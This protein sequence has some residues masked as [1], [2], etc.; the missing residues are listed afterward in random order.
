MTK[1]TIARHIKDNPH[2]AYLIEGR[3]AEIVPE[4]FASLEAEGFSPAGNP[5]LY[6]ITL[7]TMKVDDARE[8]RAQAVEKSF[9]PKGKA[10]IIAANAILGDAENTLL[11]MLEEPVPGTRFF[12]I[13]PDR[14][15]LLGTLLSRMHVIAGER[16]SEKKEAEAFV[17]M[18]PAARIEYLKNFMAEAKE[19]EEDRA[20][21][22]ARSRALRFLDSLESVLH[23]QFFGG[24]S[25]PAHEV[26]FFEQIFRV[27][28]YLRMPGSSVKNLME[29]VALAVPAAM[30]AR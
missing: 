8:L 14:H 29:S 25:A 12:L 2:H 27:R 20:A 6:Q 5:D 22:S 10:F 3:A 9:N 15:V 30:P 21:D 17:A 4:I 19:D 23:E 24:A 16:G 7:D 28:G 18:R 13:V 11:K 26:A 1:G